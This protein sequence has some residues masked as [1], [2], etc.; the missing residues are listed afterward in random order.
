[1][2]EDGRHVWV[3]HECIDGV[4]EFMLPYPQWHAIGL[5]PAVEP[6]FCCAACGDHEFLWM[7]CVG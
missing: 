1:M 5:S 6:S 7:S 3:S 4:Q 2:D